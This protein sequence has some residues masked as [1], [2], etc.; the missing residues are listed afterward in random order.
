MRRSVRGEGMR[1]CVEEGHSCKT[2][3]EMRSAITID[4][5]SD[6][7]EIK[8]FIVGSSGWGLILESTMAILERRVPL[9]RRKIQNG[10]IN[11]SERV[12]FI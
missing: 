12:S 11:S 1:R 5:C 2:K 10:K 9:I 7:V 6:R 4:P 3:Y 8:A